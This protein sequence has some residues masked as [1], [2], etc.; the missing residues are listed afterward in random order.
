MIGT[1]WKRPVFILKDEMRTKHYDLLIQNTASK[2]EYLITGLKDTSETYLAYVFEQFSF[3][4]EAEE[5]EYV[6]FLYRNDRKD[7]VYT[8][9]DDVPETEIETSDGTV[10][11]KNLRPEMFIIKYGT[12]RKPYVARQKNNEYYYYNG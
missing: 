6:C 5:G 3:P 9:N 7:C 1:G 2:K 8:F 12:I 4:E 10:K 11:V